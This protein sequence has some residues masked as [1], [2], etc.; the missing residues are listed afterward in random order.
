[1][2]SAVER[3]F[4]IVGEAMNQLRRVDSETATAIPELPRVIAFRNILVHGYANVDNRLVWGVL[5][6]DLP[7]LLTTLGRLLA[8][9]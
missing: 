6:T 9:P 7:S 2:R 5:E 1:M 8:N 3:Q 4:E